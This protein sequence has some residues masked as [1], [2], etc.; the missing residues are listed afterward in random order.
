MRSGVS[1]GGGRV[2]RF[3]AAGRAMQKSPILAHNNAIAGFTSQSLAYRLM[4]V[5]QAVQLL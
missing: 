4:R 2:P 5:R 3:E 1:T